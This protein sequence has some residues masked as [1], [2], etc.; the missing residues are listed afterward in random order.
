[1]IGG[2][3]GITSEHARVPILKFID[4]GM[5]KDR[6]IALSENLRKVSL[7]RIQST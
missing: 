6:E 1:M 3:G 4:F 5:A 2:K 7:V